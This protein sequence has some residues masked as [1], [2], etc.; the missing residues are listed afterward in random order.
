VTPRSVK[1]GRVLGVALAYLA[2]GRVALLFAIPPGY[3]T[4][5]W[6]AAGIALAAGLLWGE[7]MWPGVLAGS[8]LANAWMVL[9]RGDG[10]ARA[11]LFAAWIGVGAAAQAAYSARLVRDAT[12]GRDP[13]ARE[14]DLF[15][16]LALGG[17]VG[18]LVSS[19][20]AAAGMRAFGIIGPREFYYS[21]TTWW[22]GDSTGVLVAAPLV[23]MW[24]RRAG[25]VERRGRAAVTAGLLTTIVV[26][27]SLQSYA[28]R[29]EERN[30]RN[31]A[32]QKLADLELTVRVGVAGHID[33][34]E[35]TADL[36][37][38]HAGV[39]RAEFARFAGGILA[40][41]PGMQAL[42]WR[43]RVPD[44]QR[45]AVE[46]RARRDGLLSFSFKG[47]E[48]DGTLAPRA[49]A[50]EYFPILYAE[51]Y[52]GNETALG[53]DINR[54]QPE[55]LD[56]AVR[57]LVTGR[58]AGSGGV[59]LV[60]EHEGQTGVAVLVPVVRA[61]NEP[62]IGL[63]EGV[64]RVGDMMQSLLAG[65]DADALSVRVVD[66]TVPEEPK[67]LFARGRPLEEAL[68]TVS[69]TGDFAGRRWRVT[70]LPNAGFQARARTPLSWFSLAAALAFTSLFSW[71]LLTLHAR[72]LD[73]AGAGKLG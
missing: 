54:Q 48:P 57:A 42:E 21:W 11:Y 46:A 67:L 49:R 43:P 35:S 3:S 73:A 33:A 25:A 69:M 12:G 6:P 13:L 39:T 31:L 14:R 47:L 9:D 53:L 68:G 5:V 30:T 50:G 34:L 4:I 58:P 29:N 65:F 17:P 55:V 7:A 51:P 16:F 61:P 72:W 32:A 26:C 62:A 8:V 44:A 20:W 10:N 2:A 28:I 23:L 59:H 63:V 27:S 19:S 37:A 56:A 38:S 1:A 70:L 52:A 64:F 45:A 24:A 71:A 22:V 36:F 60:Q 66:E 40:R 18:C 41:H 15:W